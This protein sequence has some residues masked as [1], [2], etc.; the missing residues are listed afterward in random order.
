M[1]LTRRLLSTLLLA[2][3]AT[4]IGAQPSTERPIRLIVPYAAGGNVDA[5]ARSIAPG[6]SQLLRQPV[7][8]ENRP[9]AG[10]LLAGEHVARAAP[11]GMTLFISSNGPVLHSPLIYGRPVYDWR[12]DFA[13]VGSVSF[14][15]MVLLASPQFPAKSLPEML[16]L[17]A[18]QPGQITLA[19]PG[20]GSTNH[21][22]SELLQMQRGI[23]LNTVHYKGTA[24][25]MT[26]LLGGHVQLSFDQVSVALPHLQQ[27]RVKALAVTTRQRLPQLPDVPTFAEAGLAQFEVATFVGIFAPVA[28][29]ADT[30]ARLNSALAQVLAERQV[31][32]KFEAMG[33]QARASA[34]SEFRKY[35]EQEDAVWLPVIR[36]AAIKVQ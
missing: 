24:P 27:G 8:V 4:G 16:Q 11:D 22:A 15:P 12:K 32:E 7:V 13:P 3:A 35:L 21:L 9:G 17:A 6:L 10:G 5:A 18:Q 2:S 34:P 23:R 30:V 26:D 29:P 28:T 25:A 36:N 19:T 14:T 20:A 1:P 33:A 31:I